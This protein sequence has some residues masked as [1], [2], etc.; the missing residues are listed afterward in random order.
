MALCPTCRKDLERSFNNGTSDES[1]HI[2]E[3]K[4]DETK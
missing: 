2:D 4:L 3:L 1:L